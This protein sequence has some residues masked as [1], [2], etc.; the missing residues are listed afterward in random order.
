MK[1]GWTK[2]GQTPPR[3]YRIWVAM[4][5]RCR[6]PNTRRFNCYGGRGIV[7]CER[8]QQFEKFL[9][10]MGSCPSPKHSIDRFP[11][12]DGNYEPSNCRWATWK[13]QWE[14]RRPA[15][16]N[17]DN[18]A[19]ARASGL[20]GRKAR[21]GPKSKYGLFFSAEARRQQRQVDGKYVMKR[22]GDNQS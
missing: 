1:H 3:T 12:S 5:S 13:Q 10:D 11:N 17:P 22:T 16:G 6:N 14:T 21:I 9:A 7:V 19:R 8:W 4:R 15:P 20:A 18:L 2:H